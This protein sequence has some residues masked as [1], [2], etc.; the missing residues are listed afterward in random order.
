MDRPAELQESSG[1]EARVPARHQEDT[2]TTSDSSGGEWREGRGVSVD[3]QA[4]GE[5]G[6]CREVPLVCGW[7]CV[8]FSL[9]EVECLE[10]GEA[11]VG[12]GLAQQRQPRRLRPATRVS[13]SRMIT[14]LLVGGRCPRQ[15]PIEPI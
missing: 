7:L 10:C 3:R 9:R 15:H 12:Q 14:G 6:K 8:V 1:A 11:V 13:T 4:G 5:T 2:A